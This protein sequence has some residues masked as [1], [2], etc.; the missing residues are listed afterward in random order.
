[1]VKKETVAQVKLDRPPERLAISI[2][3]PRVTL[4]CLSSLPLPNGCL[5]ATTLL[6]SVTLFGFTLAALEATQH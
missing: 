4:T 5:S 2:H 3:Q 1:M 6:L